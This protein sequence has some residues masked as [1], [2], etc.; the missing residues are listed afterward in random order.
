MCIRDRGTDTSS[1]QAGV[2]E[3]D[4]VRKRTRSGGSDGDRSG[5]GPG[6]DKSGSLAVV[7]SRQVCAVYGCSVDRDSDIAPYDAHPSR[8]Q[9]HPPLRDRFDVVASGRIGSEALWCQSRTGAGLA[10]VPLT[11]EAPHTR[12]TQKHPKGD[13]CKNFARLL[14][15]PCLRRTDIFDANSASRDAKLCRPRLGPTSTTFSAEVLCSKIASPSSPRRSVERC[16][17]NFMSHCC[18][19]A[20]LLI[21]DRLHQ[22]L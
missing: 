2:P 18:L 16:V 9:A 21:Q 3:P 14:A 19:P 22:R 5:F 13:R 15:F 1:D 17:F 8:A 12:L 4:G 11:T 7:D 10:P 6:G 20:K